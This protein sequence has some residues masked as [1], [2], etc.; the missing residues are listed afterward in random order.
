M[1]SR[2]DSMHDDEKQITFS[3]ALSE[4][5]FPGVSS[6]DSPSTASTG[7]RS[8][9]LKEHAVSDEL[10]VD[11]D[12]S[13]MGGVQDAICLIASE[14]AERYC[15]SYYALMAVTNLI[16]TKLVDTK[17][18][19]AVNARASYADQQHLYVLVDLRET[20]PSGERKHAR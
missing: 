4:V 12:S 16:L 6:S 1:S 11:F 10:V 7:S 18:Q 3:Y 8:T 19:I 2:H 5:T 9:D 15:D 20:G 13:G 17:V 14:G